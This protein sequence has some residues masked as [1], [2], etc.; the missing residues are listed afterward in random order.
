MDCNVIGNLIANIE[1][2]EKEKK[3]LENVR[4]TIIKNLQN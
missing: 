2:V 3:I 4:Y 1:I